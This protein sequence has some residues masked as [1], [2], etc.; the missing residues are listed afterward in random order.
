MT[1]LKTESHSIKKFSYPILYFQNHGHQ[2]LH[3]LKI[4][5]K[6][7]LHEATYQKWTTQQKF[8][9]NSYFSVYLVSNCIRVKTKGVKK[10][11]IRNTVVVYCS[12]S[13]YLRNTEGLVGFFEWIL[14]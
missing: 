9:R 4:R 1:A 3:K 14:S 5:A 6:S 8:C 2:S 7:H 13:K 11:L 12:E 10:Q